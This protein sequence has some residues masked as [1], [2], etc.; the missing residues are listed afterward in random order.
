MLRGHVFGLLAECLERVCWVFRGREEMAALRPGPAVQGVRAPPVTMT[1]APVTVTAPPVTMTAPPVTMTAPPVTMAAGPAAYS[2]APPYAGPGPGYGRPIGTGQAPC[3][4]GP[5]G[6]C[7]AACGGF[8]GSGARVTYGQSSSSRPRDLFSALDTNG[9]GVLSRE[10]MAALR[11]AQGVSFGGAVT[12]S[13]LED[14]AVTGQASHWPEVAGL[15]V[16]NQKDRK[17]SANRLKDAESTLEV[18]TLLFMLNAIQSPVWDI[19][20][21]ICKVCFFTSYRYLEQVLEKWY[22][23]GM[24]LYGGLLIDA[25]LTLVGWVHVRHGI[26]WI[27]L[28]IGRCYCQGPAAQAP[29]HWDSSPLALTYWPKQS[30]VIPYPDILQCVNMR[31]A[32]DEGLSRLSHPTPEHFHRQHFSHWSLSMS[33]PRMW[34]PQLMRWTSIARS[35]PRFHTSPWHVRIAWEWQAIWCSILYHRNLHISPAI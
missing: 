21:D 2:A 18:S 14:L 11:P 9:D 28:E 23:T 10:E 1:A 27:T 22:E 26:L 25:V 7:G 20:L 4:S 32:C 6:T 31:E 3:G 8:A 24:G 15:I 13:W 17:K 34:W 19:W 5:P 29:F 16:E 30:Y 35:G 12:Y 33:L